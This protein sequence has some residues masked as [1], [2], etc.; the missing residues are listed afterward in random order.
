MKENLLCKVSDGLAATKRHRRLLV[1]DICR[2]L[3]SR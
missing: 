2:E 1:M 3:L